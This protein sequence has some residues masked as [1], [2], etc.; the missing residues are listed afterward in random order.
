[1]QIYMES[2]TVEVILSLLANADKPIDPNNF[3][4]HAMNSVFAFLDVLIVSH[5]I[6]LFHVIQ[7]MAFG[8][9][10]GLFSYIY[11]VCG[12]VNV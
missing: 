12:G 10:Y 6:R 7:P 1:M 9:T 3:L 11:Y 4:S 2:V 5:P 8:L